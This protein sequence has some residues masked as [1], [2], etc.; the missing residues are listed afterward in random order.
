[1]AQDAL[2][3]RPVLREDSRMRSEDTQPANEESHEHEDEEFVSALVL[4]RA[5][6]VP[7]VGRRAGAGRTAA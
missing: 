1:M 7:R 4:T 6:A 5:G 2:T 3:L